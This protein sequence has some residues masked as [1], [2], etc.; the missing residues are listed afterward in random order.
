MQ[1]A[2]NAEL[3]DGR[4]DV[5]MSGKAS[6]RRALIGLPKVFDGTHLDLPHVHVERAREVRI[7]AHRPFAV[8]ADG[9]PIGHLPAT[10]RVRPR[11]V[12]V[13]VPA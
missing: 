9:D 13:L 3:D 11:A 1:L 7:A 5:V 4:L 2:P 8:Y 12:R 6:K 10:V